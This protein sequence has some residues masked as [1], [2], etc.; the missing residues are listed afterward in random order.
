MSDQP[1]TSP[2]AV[3]E[4]PVVPPV[5]PPPVVPPVTPEPPAANPPPVA[6]VEPP[7]VP[8]VTPPVATPPATFE[9][10]PPE[11]NLLTKEYVA[12]FQK[13]A[14]TAGLS[15]DEAQD[16]LDTQY[17]AVKDYEDRNKQ[18]IESAKSEWA[19]QSKTAADIGGDNFSRTTEMSKRVLQAF[20]TNG[21][22]AKL[23]DQT[24]FGN[25]HSVLRFLS[26][27]G[28]VIGEDRL[29]PGSASSGGTTKSREEILFGATSPS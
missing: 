17:R 22:M 2:T 29:R 24:G 28:N 3:I 10:K 8:A 11:G 26:K 20:D 6:K 16:L 15:K 21:E 25:Y 23:M 5:T 14:I 13:D 18:S 4:P 19:T 27:I 7:V 1:I 12:Q 9:L